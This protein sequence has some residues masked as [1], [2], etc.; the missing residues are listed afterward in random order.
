MTLPGADDQTFIFIKDIFLILL[1]GAGLAP[2]II[3]LLS[4]RKD[5]AESKKDISL[6]DKTRIEGE[7]DMAEFWK[8]SATDLGKRLDELSVRLDQETIKRQDCN[9]RL[10]DMQ[11]EINVLKA[12]V[13]DY[14]AQVVDLKEQLTNNKVIIDYLN[15]KADIVVQ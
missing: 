4:K 9:A 8:K 14:E 6:A 1:G 10:N 11:D 3:K 15:Q 13:R 7:I 5:D 2:I 12:Q